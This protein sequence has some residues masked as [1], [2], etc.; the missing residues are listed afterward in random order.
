MLFISVSPTVT[1]TYSP[2]DRAG[3]R[4]PPGGVARISELMSVRL[5]GSPCS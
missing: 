2:E 4:G 3:S 5:F 1:L